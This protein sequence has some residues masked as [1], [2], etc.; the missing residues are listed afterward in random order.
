MLRSPPLSQSGKS[1][2][3]TAESWLAFHWKPNEWQRFGRD[4][5]TYIHVGPTDTSPSHDVAH[6]MLAAGSRLPWLPFGADRQIRLAEFNAVLLEHLCCAAIKG[7]SHEKALK[8]ARWFVLE[9]YKPF[10]VTF[11]EALEAW[12][13]GIDVESVLR[14]SPVFFNQR[15]HEL[16]RPDFAKR[17]HGSRF[18]ASLAPEVSMENAKA[19]TELARS[20]ACLLEP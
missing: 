6:L 12:K 7:E 18:L 4:A 9:H 17:E 13:N 3:A 2:I 20:L 1:M 8:H 15:R 16:A 19:V 11:E 5:D 14:L 10:P